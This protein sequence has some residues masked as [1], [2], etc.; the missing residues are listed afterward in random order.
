[1]LFSMGGLMFYGGLIV[2]AGA[3][4]WY[5]RRYDL[6]IPP[7]ADAAAPTLMLAYGI[8]RVGCHLAGNG[9]WGIAADLAA[10]PDWLPMWLW[11]KTSPNAI[12]GLPEQPVYP[13]SVYEAIAAMLLFGV[14]WAL[15]KPPSRPAGSSRSTSS[16][17]AS[18][19]SS[20]R[21]SGSPRVPPAGPHADAGRDHLRGA[22]HR[23]RFRAPRPGEREP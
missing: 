18:S 7:I 12:V 13:I 3:I 22:R 10:R 6:P 8:G 17:T 20:S 11:A 23:R 9:D 5:L 21:R 15:R 14:L 19:A 1:M 2:A 16:S 4:I